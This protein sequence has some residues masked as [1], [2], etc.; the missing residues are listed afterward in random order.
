MSTDPFAAFK[1]AQR[2]GWALFSPL[3]AFT[4]PAA[5][6][7]VDF[8]GIRAGQQVLDVA[9]GTGVVA[10]TAARAGAH[11]KGLDLSP[12]LLVDARRNAAV[13]DADI[14]FVEGDA[15]SLP[16][17]DAS[18]DVVLSQFGHMFAPRPDVVIAQMLRV[19][20]PGGRIAFS[21]WPPELAIGRLFDLVGSYLPPPA[22]ASA[23]TAWGNV[24]TVRE[25]LGDAVRD[26]EFGREELTIPALSVRHY[27]RN[28]EMTAAPFV[29]L[30]QVMADQPEKLAAFRA[31]VE[32]IVAQYFRGNR[33]HQSFLMTRATKK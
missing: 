5:A 29:K 10:I 3:A 33:V 8:A 31:Q 2:E 6:A 18:F 14:E 30:V 23:P 20:K 21:T 15:E 12:A 19:L 9:C 26:L 22:G 28:M 17:P 25:R 24:Q 32:A 13:I 11:V 16:Y 4:T 1:A 7:L 27:C